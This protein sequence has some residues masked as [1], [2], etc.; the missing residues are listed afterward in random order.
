MAIIQKNKILTKNIVNKTIK[1]ELTLQTT[2]TFL[3]YIKYV[4]TP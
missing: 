2:L 4:Q 3:K 1:K